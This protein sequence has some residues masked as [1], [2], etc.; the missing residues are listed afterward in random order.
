MRA[1]HAKRKRFNQRIMKTRA[2]EYFASRKRTKTSDSEDSDLSQKLREI[3]LEPLGE[4]P[5]PRRRFPTGSRRKKF[6]QDAVKFVEGRVHADDSTA[7]RTEAS[8]GERMSSFTGG[9]V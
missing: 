1:R 4:I 9:I 8:I 6:P 2:K 7:V 3:P 5:P